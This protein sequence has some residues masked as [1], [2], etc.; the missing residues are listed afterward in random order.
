VVRGQLTRRI[1]RN[2]DLVS[3][4]ATGSENNTGVRVAK[5]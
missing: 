4:E 1:H 2:E 3:L 5:V